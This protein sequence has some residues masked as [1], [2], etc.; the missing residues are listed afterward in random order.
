MTVV[1]AGTDASAARAVS[2]PV[3]HP[4]PSIAIDTAWLGEYLLGRWAA[5]RRASRAG[6]LEQR[7]H[8]IPGQSMAEHRERVFGQ[9]RQ[10]V[11]DDAVHRAFPARHVLE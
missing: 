1:E 5:D 7:Y 10:L 3:E 9:L 6:M 2:A 4:E 8:R 11:A